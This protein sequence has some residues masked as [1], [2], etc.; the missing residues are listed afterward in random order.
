MNDIRMKGP[1]IKLRNLRETI[2]PTQRGITL[3][4]ITLQIF[5]CIYI[6]IQYI[7]TWYIYIPRF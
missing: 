5:F 4:K 1:G 3:N 7:Y 2:R 6:Y